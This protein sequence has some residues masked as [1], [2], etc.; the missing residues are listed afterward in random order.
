MAVHFDF[1]CNCCFSAAACS[2]ARIS[3][4]LDTADALVVSICIPWLRVRP[5][6]V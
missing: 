2:S 3:L 4:G 1:A 6:S 5:G